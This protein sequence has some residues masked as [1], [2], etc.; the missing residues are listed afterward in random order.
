MY[1]IQEVGNWCRS[2]EDIR[3]ILSDDT[4]RFIES[5]INQESD[6]AEDR[7]ILLKDELKSYEGSLEEYEY[8]ICDISSGIKEIN[9]EVNKKRWNK[10]KIISLVS[11]VKK[12][13]K[14]EDMK[15]TEELMNLCLRTE[16]EKEE[17]EKENLRLKE[18]L[19]RI[20]RINLDLREKYWQVNGNPHDI[21]SKFGKLEV[22]DIPF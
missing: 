7:I 1:Y 4:Y 18:E 13:I 20:E 9:K 3:D 2:L 10:E 5:L 17:L 12:L 11:D 15:D 6:S 14:T 19:E 16:K 22:D 21:K 8:L